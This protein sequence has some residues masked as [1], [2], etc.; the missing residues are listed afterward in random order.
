MHAGSVL[1]LDLVQSFMCQGLHEGRGQDK[2]AFVLALVPPL[3]V[4]AAPGP[5]LSQCLGAYP[6]EDPAGPSPGPMPKL[7]PA[8]SPPGGRA[9]KSPVF[10]VGKGGRARPLSETRP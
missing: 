2:T 8:R 10:K 4:I 9:K 1:A 3:K 7:R 6:T 5:L